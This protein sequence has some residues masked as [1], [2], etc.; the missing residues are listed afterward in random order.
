[1]LLTL[2]KHMRMLMRLPN[3]A[4][5]SSAPSSIIPLWHCLRLQAW[6]YM[7][8]SMRARALPRAGPP[9]TDH[10]G[11]GL[12]RRARV[13]RREDGTCLRR[14][15]GRRTGI[16][17]PWCPAVAPGTRRNSRPGERVSA[18]A[19]ARP[20]GSGRPWPAL[21]PAQGP[22]CCSAPPAHRAPRRSCSVQDAQIRS[23]DLLGCRVRDLLLHLQAVVL[24]DAALPCVEYRA[25]DRRC[26]AP[27][28]LPYLSP[29]TPKRR[30]YSDEFV[31]SACNP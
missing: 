5:L 17:A 25:P 18:T 2:L 1:M 6:H 28:L 11:L 21:H 30:L 15:Q 23:R 12:S 3:I 14:E 27:V 9:H 19:A 24:F 13:L 4:A 31:F 10:G 26:C 20:R 16:A 7:H 8:E 29:H 22:G